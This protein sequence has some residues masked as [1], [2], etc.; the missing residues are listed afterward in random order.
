M[1]NQPI[2]MTGSLTQAA[3]AGKSASIQR[4][5]TIDRAELMN[6]GNSQNPARSG[7]QINEAMRFRVKDMSKSVEKL[8]D[9]LAKMQTADQGLQTTEKALRKM[10]DLAVKASDEKLSPDERASLNEE[11]KKMRSVINRV[12]DKTT[13]DDKKLLDG[14]YSERLQTGAS[15]NHA[16]NVKIGNMSARGIGV[17]R[18]DISSAA[19]AK[20]ALTD[21]NNALN[22]VSAQRKQ[23]GKVQTKMQETADMQSRVLDKLRANNE[24]LS[25]DSD[26]KQELQQLRD[27]LTGMNASTMARM[28]NMNNNNA[29]QLLFGSNK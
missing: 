1:A 13:V 11:L 22:K 6:Q 10:K 4:S 16:D 7:V 18:T 21:I 28:Y 2:N 5:G 14:K 27:N 8:Q 12:A 17:D 19:S 20:D 23:L 24:Q 3:Y 9:N 25:K 26:V 29:F 15:A